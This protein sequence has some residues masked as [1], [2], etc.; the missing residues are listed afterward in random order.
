MTTIRTRIARLTAASAV[1]VSLGALAAG[2]AAAQTGTDTPS[3]KRYAQTGTDIPSRPASAGWTAVKS[4]AVTFGDIG[5]RYF[6]LAGGRRHRLHARR[7]RPRARGLGEP[8]RR[9]PGHL[10]RRRHSGFAPAAGWPEPGHPAAD[11]FTQRSS[12]RRTGATA[13]PH[14]V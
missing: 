2:P 13:M 6:Q 9:H 10:S 8:R 14:P 1:V 3:A 4:S 12:I 11:P 5:S 7:H